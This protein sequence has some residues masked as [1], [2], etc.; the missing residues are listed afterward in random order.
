MSYADPLLIEKQHHHVLAHID[1]SSQ[2]ILKAIVG[3]LPLSHQKHLQAHTMPNDGSKPSYQVALE[4]LE[5]LGRIDTKFKQLYHEIRFDLLPRHRRLAECID[6]Y[7]A[8]HTPENAVNLVLACRGDERLTAGPVA[9]SGMTSR[10]VALAPVLQDKES[11]AVEP[12]CSIR[13]KL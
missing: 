3:F 10:L 7:L 13:A 2:L 6:V 12:V 8:N 1:V 4:L 9:I 11:K 5:V